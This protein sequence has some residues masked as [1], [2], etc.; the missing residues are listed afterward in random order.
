MRFNYNRI[1]FVIVLNAAFLHSSIATKADTTTNEITLQPGMFIG[2]SWGLALKDDPTF[3]LGGYIGRYKFHQGF[4]TDL[5]FGYKFENGLSLSIESGYIYNSV[6]NTM[7]SVD[8]QQ[9]PI[10]L[11]LGYELPVTPRFHPFFAAAAG[12]A[13]SVISDEKNSYQDTTLAYQAEIGL[14]YAI[15][16]RCSVALAYKY[17]STGNLRFR[18]VSLDA[19]TTHAALVNFSFAL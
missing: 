3:K 11:K 9:I 17:L 14:R 7:A 19:V 18:P 13:I 1:L 12:P 4:R 2:T 5:E 6:L 15:S 10:L 16:K 8:L